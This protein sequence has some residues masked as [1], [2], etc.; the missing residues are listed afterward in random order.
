VPRV[1][2]EL[3]FPETPRAFP[4]RRGVKILL[5]ALHVLSTGVLCGAT[6][7]DVGPPV[8][9]TWL[10]AAAV[11]GL[12]IVLLDLFESGAF[13][14]QLRGL[15]VALKIALLAGLPWFGEYAGWILAALVLL[16]VVSSH[17]PGKVRYLVLLGGGRITG[18]DS[19]G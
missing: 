9:T 17:S 11:T 13:M 19:R 1:A 6:L 4:G 5:R 8:R 10:I 2:W 12:L 14:L 18:S 3:L 15:L 7:L 16:S